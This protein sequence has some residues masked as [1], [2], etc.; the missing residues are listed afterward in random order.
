MKNR[1]LT[2]E[3]ARD[4]IAGVKPY[5]AVEEEQKH[6]VRLAKA[7]EDAF[8]KIDH[9]YL[10]NLVETAEHHVTYKDYWLE[11][12]MSRH[13]EERQRIIDIRD[14]AIA[15]IQSELKCEPNRTFIIY[16]GRKEHDFT[17][18]IQ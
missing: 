4:Y 2:D 6:L 12:D 11:P 16:E 14:K 8:E 17:R 18:Y 15:T 5:D 3:Q 1:K 13:A 7:L 9:K 10:P